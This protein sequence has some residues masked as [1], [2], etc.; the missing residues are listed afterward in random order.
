MVI[1]GTSEEFSTGSH[2][3]KPPKP[4]ASYAQAPPM[5]MPVPKIMITKKL[6]GMAGAI[7]PLKSLRTSPPMAYANGTKVLAKPK[8]SVGG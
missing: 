4:S 5:R 1:H 6:H 2:A 3:Q 8:N 7:Q